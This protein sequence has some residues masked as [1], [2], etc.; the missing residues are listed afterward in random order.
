VPATESS[1]FGE[2]A[3]RLEQHVTSPSRSDVRDDERLVHERVQGPEDLVL[4]LVADDIGDRGEGE[5]AREH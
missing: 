5:A 3:N 1:S 4:F 2:L